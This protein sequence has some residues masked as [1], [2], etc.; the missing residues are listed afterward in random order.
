[1]VE[2]ISRNNT[3]SFYTIAVNG[4]L[5]DW[6]SGEPEYT[7]LMLSIDNTE[8]NPTWDFIPFNKNTIDT[9][10]YCEKPSL[11]QIKRFANENDLG[12]HIR[13]P[14][15]VDSIDWSTVEI[16]EITVT[17]TTVIELNMINHETG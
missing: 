7:R 11:N 14:Y 10:H 17:S 13:I 15:N 9:V 6:D 1:M 3:F 8:R 5:K 16:I 12:R 2:T 4:L